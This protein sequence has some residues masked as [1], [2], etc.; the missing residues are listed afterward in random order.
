MFTCGVCSER[1]VWVKHRV[2]KDA[3]DSA[4][5]IDICYDCA[6]MCGCSSC[7]DFGPKQAAVAAPVH[8]M[9]DSSDDDDIFFFLSE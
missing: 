8:I 9:D 7:T 1:E 2:H 3:V 4:T 5:D 6:L